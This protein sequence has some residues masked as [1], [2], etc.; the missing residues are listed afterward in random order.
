MRHIVLVAL[1][2][3]GNSPSSSHIDAP[4]GDGH[5]DASPDAGD[6]G[7]YAAYAS[8]G[9]LDHLRVAKTIAG[10]CFAIDLASPGS[11]GMRVTLPA[12]WGLTMA[13][14]MQPSAA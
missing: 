9:G 10:T 14:A 3:C 4:L 8:I 2:A 5:A 13:T 7:M 11:N 1:F 6:P 12:N